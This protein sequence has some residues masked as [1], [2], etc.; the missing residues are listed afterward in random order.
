M[1]WKYA[2][3]PLLWASL[4]QFKFPDH[5]YVYLTRPYDYALNPH[6]KE[7][8]EK[9]INEFIDFTNEGLVI[10]KDGIEITS[11]FNDLSKKFQED[12]F[13]TQESNPKLLGKMFLHYREIYKKEK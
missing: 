2:L 3:D 9:I 13:E 10:K 1:R 6:E 7:V 8:I 5:L 4:Q 12:L 11:R